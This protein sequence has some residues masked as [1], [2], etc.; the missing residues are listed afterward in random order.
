MA[1]G[2][3]VNLPL[4][5]DCSRCGP[6]EPDERSDQGG[7]GK[8]N[9]VTL[10][11]TAQ[12]ICNELRSVSFTVQP[13]SGASLNPCPDANHAIN[14]CIY[15]LDKSLINTLSRVKLG[16]K[17]PEILNDKAWDKFTYRLLSSRAHEGSSNFKIIV[18]L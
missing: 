6:S 9:N 2:K 4:V 15:S 16:R 5:A 17:L 8:S 13:A 1:L 12:N 3:P 14:I 7:S 10:S 11:L 18:Y